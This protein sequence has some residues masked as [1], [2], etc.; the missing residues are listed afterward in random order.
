MEILYYQYLDYLFIKKW[1]LHNLIPIEQKAIFSMLLLKSSKE[2]IRQNYNE[3]QSNL[4]IVWK[5]REVG[6]NGAWIIRRTDIPP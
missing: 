5:K 2:A 6:N 1:I 3:K 4:Y